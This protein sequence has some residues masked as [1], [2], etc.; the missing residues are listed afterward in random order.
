MK[1]EKVEQVSYSFCALFSLFIPQNKWS[2][3]CTSTMFTWK[4]HIV[5]WLQS[6]TL[7]VLSI[8]ISIYLCLF[9]K[10]NTTGQYTELLVGNFNFFLF[11]LTKIVSVYFLQTDSKLNQFCLYKEMTTA[12]ATNRYNIEY[13]TV[14]NSL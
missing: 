5:L 3:G 1:K 7:A 2:T 11:F 13:K 8:N 9:Y 12:I 14:I 6:G 10:R 4:S